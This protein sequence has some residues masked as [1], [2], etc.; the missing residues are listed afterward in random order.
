MNVPNMLTVGRILMIPLMVVSYYW[1]GWGGKTWAAGLFALAAVTDWFDGYLARRWNQS[2][3]LGAF[4]DP[5]ADKLIVA[6]ALMVLVEA[7][8][9]PWVTIPAMIIVGREIVISALRE[10]MAELGKRRS[11]AVS[12]LGKVKTALQMISIILLLAAQEHTFLEWY[13]LVSL[14]VAALLTLWSMIVYLQ[15][16][17]PDLRESH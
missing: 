5:V 16:A 14:Y 9:V 10:W 2:T 12:W 3:P 6:A 13:G 7:Y 11:V 15:A 1:L 4:L 8:S 17:W